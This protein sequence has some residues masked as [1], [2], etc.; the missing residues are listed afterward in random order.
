M[1]RSRRK[2]VYYDDVTFLRQKYFHQKKSEVEN[3]YRIVTTYNE[4]SHIRH[5]FH[6]LLCETW[7]FKV[8]EWKYRLFLSLLQSS[9]VH[10][11][12]H[13]RCITLVPHTPVILW[14]DVQW[15][16]FLLLLRFSTLEVLAVPPTTTYVRHW[17]QQ[18]FMNYRQRRHWMILSVPIRI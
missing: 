17:C 16:S 13:N 6:K 5:K 10:N 8:V 15:S 11:H 2:R 3:N 1:T 9:H 14:I 18:T 12:F 4:S 7:L